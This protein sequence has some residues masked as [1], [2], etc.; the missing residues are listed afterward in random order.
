MLIDDRR[1]QVR[2]LLEEIKGLTS[3]ERNRVAALD[4]PIFDSLTVAELCRAHGLLAHDH[5]FNWKQREDTW[6]DWR[7][8]MIRAVEG[9][10]RY[11]TNDALLITIGV[12][13]A[14]FPLIHHGAGLMGYKTLDDVVM[15]SQRVGNLNKRER[16][17]VRLRIKDMIRRVSL[18][19]YAPDNVLLDREPSTIPYGTIY[20]G[21]VEAAGIVLDYN[22]PATV[23][24]LV[25][26]VMPIR[27]QTT[28]TKT[29][30][31]PIAYSN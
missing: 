29:L 9:S 25:E 18:W 19:W 26:V 4:L 28:H 20:A 6:H 5:T 10:L 30:I 2:K 13:A 3:D 12:S 22:E 14:L 24:R 11:H 15:A 21:A 1:H 7:D 16:S 31:M 8:H 23:I 27:W 17:E